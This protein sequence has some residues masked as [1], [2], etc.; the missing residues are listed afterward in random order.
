MLVVA[1]GILLL[2]G[3]AGDRGQGAS[4]A[5]PTA[6]PTPT[7]P[8]KSALPLEEASALPRSAPAA[9]QPVTCALDTNGSDSASTQECLRCHSSVDGGPIHGNHPVDLDYA[10]AEG[11]AGRSGTLRPVGEVVRRG[12]LLPDGKLQ[13]VTC[14]DARSPWAAKIALPP[15]SVAVPALNPRNPST[16]EDRDR[17]RTTGP[18]AQPPPPGTAVSSTPLCIACHALD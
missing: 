9:S 7:A 14:H 12:V 2:A 10:A 17:L 8:A 6:S 13:C 5:R 15:G 11:E 16:Y 4:S 3:A 1:G 18:V